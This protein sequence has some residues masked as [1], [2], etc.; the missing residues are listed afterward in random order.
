MRRP[1][2]PGRPGD[3]PSRRCPPISRSSP[4]E[5]IAT[6]KI[7]PFAVGGAARDTALAG[8]RKPLLR[9]APFA[10]GKSGWS[11]PSCQVSDQGHRKD[12]EDHRRAAR[13]RGAAITPSGACRMSARHR[14]RA[15]R[16][17]QSRHGTRHR[18]RR[19]RDCRSSRR[20]PGGIGSD[21]R[22]IEHFG[23]PVDPGNLLM[24][25]AAGSLGD[26]RARLRAQSQGE[27]FRLGPHA[28]AGRS[29]GA[30]RGHH[31]ARRRRPVDGNRHPAAAARGAAAPGRSIA[32]IVLGAGRSSRM[33]GPNKLFAEI[34]GRPLIRIVAEQALRRGASG[35]RRHRPSAR[36][37]RGGACRSA[38]E[39]RA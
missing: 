9:V 19:L 29:C 18:I 16:S 1:A 25:G 4:V 31:R 15:Q 14:W 10:G 17:A 2:Q 7:I 21:R 8:V 27:R 24:I 38:G 35:D 28:V 20:H 12:A 11:R 6:V 39:I 5:M 37:R 34:G 23:M 33:G 30:A 22:R 32:A 13:A 3:A 26:R 36:A